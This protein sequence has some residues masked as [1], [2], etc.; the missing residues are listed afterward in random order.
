M[1]T[2]IELPAAADKPAKNYLV[3]T[4]KIVA[5][6]VTYLYEEGKKK[7]LAVLHRIWVD[8]RASSAWKQHGAVPEQRYLVMGSAGLPVSAPP[9]RC[10]TLTCAHP[11]PRSM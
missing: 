8:L 10:P 9:C 2:R 3:S 4:A 6:A 1:A 5:A 7:S 11:H